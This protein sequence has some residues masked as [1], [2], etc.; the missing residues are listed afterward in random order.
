VQY[1][2]AI[3]API[4]DALILPNNSL[5]LSDINQNM[6]EHSDSGLQQWKHIAKF[7]MA[8]MYLCN[9]VIVVSGEN[10]CSVDFEGNVLWSITGNRYMNR[11]N[12]HNNEIVNINIDMII[13]SISCNG[14]VK[15]I[16]NILSDDLFSM[17]FSLIVHIYVTT[18]IRISWLL[19]VMVSFDEIYR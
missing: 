8:F 16:Y 2:C 5:I 12:I 18:R 17:S 15:H 9:N 1:F 10:T 14:V 19:L 4:A 13:D 3:Q 7:Y 11:L 6:Y